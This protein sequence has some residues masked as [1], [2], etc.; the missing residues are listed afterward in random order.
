MPNDKRCSSGFQM[1]CGN[2][3]M[4]LVELI[5]APKDALMVEVT[6][7]DQL[8]VGFTSTSTVEVTCIP[9]GSRTKMAPH[10]V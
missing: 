2:C 8:M 5:L 6:A 4:R 7:Y 3:G 9:G 1:D 10:L